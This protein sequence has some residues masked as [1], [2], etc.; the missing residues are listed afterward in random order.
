MGVEKEANMPLPR[1]KA[2]AS[3]AASNHS[4]KENPLASGFLSND[5][6]FPMGMEDASSLLG[7]VMNKAIRRELAGWAGRGGRRNHDHGPGESR[8]AH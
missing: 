6:Q 2:Y 7:S 5:L 1:R 4:K 8:V 3:I